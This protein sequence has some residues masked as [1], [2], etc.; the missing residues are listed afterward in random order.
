MNAK[1]KKKLRD[2]K[3]KFIKKVL[4]SLEN[5]DDITDKEA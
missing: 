2:K 5:D 1:E 3:K 4:K